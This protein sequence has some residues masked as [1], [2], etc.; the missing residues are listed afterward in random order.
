MIAI[1][2]ETFHSLMRPFCPF[3]D[4]PH[5][6]VAVSGGADSMA[7]VLLADR[8]ARE[9][10]GDVIAL[11]VDH[12]L[13]SA[14]ASEAAQVRDWLSRRAIRHRILRWEGQKPTSG[15][16]AAARKVRYELMTNWCQLNNVLHLLVAHHGDDQAETILLR[17]EKGSG[18]YGLSGMAPGRA[19][20]GVR[21]LRPFLLRRRRE[22]E[23]TLKAWRQPWLDDPSNTDARYSRTAARRKLRNNEPNFIFLQNLG[24]HAADQRQRQSHKRAMLAARTVR[25]H[26]AGFCWLDSLEDRDE[27]LAKSL[28]ADILLCIGGGIYRPRRERLDR[29]YEKMMSHTARTREIFPGHTLAGARIIHRVSGFLI[30][31]ETGRLPPP[32]FL[33]QNHN[34]RWDRFFWSLSNVKDQNLNV[35]PLGKGGWHQVR[36]KTGANLPDLVQFGLPSLKQGSKVIAVPHLNFESTEDL[37]IN[38]QKIRFNLIFAPQLP[39]QPDGLLL[40]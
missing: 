36:G 15:I 28:L 38:G 10:G 3:E 33:N 14:S 27:F 7:L 6:A 25:L 1:N 2:A 39:L 22:I 35:G 5:L 26:P 9:Q 37:K 24:R 21:L 11:T 29:L 16:Q 18:P 34:G 23:S 12:G 8:W 40:V 4:R 32:I 30:C 13:R 17:K 19:L 31:R 20:N